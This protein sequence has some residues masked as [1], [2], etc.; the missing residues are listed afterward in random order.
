[1]HDGFS[2]L[3]EPWVLV[4]TEDGTTDGVS[5]LDLFRRAP[6]I[7][8]IVGDIPTQ[9]FAILRIALAV[10]ARAV[11]GPRDVDAGERLWNAPEPPIGKI[12]AYL[13]QHRERFDLFHPATPFFQVAD[14]HTAKH[15]FSRLEKLIADVPAGH[16]YFTT[17][18]GRGL[19]RI[20]PAEAAR[21]LVHVHAFDASGIKS[22][23]V[24][25][26]RVKGGKGY[27]IGTGAAGA[28]GGLY[29]DGGDLWRTLLLNTIPLDDRGVQRDR[30]DRPAWEADPSGPAEADDLTAR[31]YGPL[32]L[33]TWQSRR[34]RLV[35]D[36]D[37]VTGVLVANG[38]KLTPQ[39]RH[40]QEPMSAWRR[41]EPQQKKLGLPVVYMPREHA[42]G[43]ALWRG[44]GAL[45]PLVAPRGK[46]DGGQ[47]FVTAAVIEWASDVLDG[48][49]RVTLRT[50]G[51][52]YG[53]QNASVEDVIDDRLVIPVAVLSAEHPRHAQA[54]VDAVAATESAVRSLGYLAQDLAR[55]GGAREPKLLEG[56]R[57]DAQRQA[58]ALLD[59]PYRA[60]LAGLTADTDPLAA[61]ERWHGVAKDLLSGIA[62]ALVEDC[63]PDAW[64]GRDVAVGSGTRHV[65][66]PEADGR[67]RYALADALPVPL[68]STEEP[69]A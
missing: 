38:D 20:S 49:A 46:A 37:G 42:A 65:S 30:R 1:M 34:V 45:L 60:W 18:A 16:Q 35:G 19:A 14:L 69:A 28:L 33:F 12:E 43:R 9:G 48:T 56:A 44:L 66:T 21:W 57:D 63:G 58:Y 47:P 6:R 3:D 2:L 40:R 36:R 53:T 7:R 41:S 68:T 8:E 4:L 50:S 25:D 5:L 64:V 15:E 27:P 67:F 17:R 32:D 31:P 10:L 23:A 52:T 54:A 22:G 61:R 24:G 62:R 59:A 26:D 51:M 11:D 29:V 55:A 39:N 13:E